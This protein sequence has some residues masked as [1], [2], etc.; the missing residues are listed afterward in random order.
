LGTHVRS[1]EDGKVL[2]SGAGP[3]GYGLMVII[4]HESKLVTVY[5]HNRANL[6]REG[7]R[8]AK[9]QHIAYVG[10]SG[11]AKGPYLHFE[12]RVEADPFDPVKVLPRGKRR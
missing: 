1:A 10:N 2:F 8:V 9:G 5:A 12:V 7:Q 6:V 3:E 4:Q 11:N